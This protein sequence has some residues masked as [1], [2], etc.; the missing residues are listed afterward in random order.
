MDYSDNSCM[1]QFTEG[2]ILRMQSMYVDLRLTYVQGSGG[3]EDDG[4]W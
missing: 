2:Q 4:G 1:N 3:E